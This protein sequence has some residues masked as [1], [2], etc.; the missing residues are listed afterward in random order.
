MI[1]LATQPGGATWTYQ[2]L[3]TFHNAYSCIAGCDWA[4]CS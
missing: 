3:T 2:Y 4:K 1:G